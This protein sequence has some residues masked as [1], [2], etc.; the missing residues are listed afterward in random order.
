MTFLRCLPGLAALGVLVLA[1]VV[2]AADEPDHEKPAIPARFQP[3][4]PLH[5]PLGKPQ[6][7][8]WLDQHEEP[9]QTYPQ[10][11]RGRPVRPD[12]QRRTLY[13][14]P[15]GDFDPTQQKILD[16]T[17]EFLSI[18][19]QLPVKIQ[20]AMAL[21]VIPAKARRKHPSWGMPQILTT[22]VLDD[23]LRP[24]LPKDAC[25]ELALTTSD[26]WPGK[27]WNFVFGQASLRD[28]VGVWS[29]YRNGDPHRDEAALRLCLRRT[30]KTAS[31]ET[32][33]MFSMEHCT[34]FECNM[35][36]SNNLAEADRL[37]LSL[38]PVCLA[39]LCYAT[40]ADPVK[41]FRELAAFAKTHGLKEEQAFYE[42]SLAAMTAKK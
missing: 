16:A 18:Y 41:R 13:V 33:H 17:A 4:L 36:G 29:I 39:K 26:L 35:C 19:F 22:Y 20:K 14:Q 8:D 5:V 34:L 10:Y 42:K 6:P 30:L 21:D 28:R 23:L 24:Q 40:G 38:C 1:G 25:V 3:L 15:L 27:G 9:G 2:G 32:G 37:P 12:R 11:V 7:G 31:H